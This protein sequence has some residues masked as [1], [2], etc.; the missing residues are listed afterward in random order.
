MKPHRVTRLLA[1]LAIAG[2]YGGYCT[3]ARAAEIVVTTTAW[4]GVSECTLRD[5]ITA[6]NSDLPTGGCPA[7]SGADTIVLA[8]GAIYLLDTIDNTS[9]ENGNVQPNGLPSITSAVTITGNGT[10]IA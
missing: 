1:T 10:T 3:T 7:G 5:A 8:P 6:A 9:Q 4:K 2:L